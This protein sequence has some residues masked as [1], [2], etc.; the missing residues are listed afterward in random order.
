ML[1]GFAAILAAFDIKKPLDVCGNEY[2]PQ[3]E[4]MKVLEGYVI[5]FH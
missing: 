2:D 5:L 4:Y 1:L 3:I